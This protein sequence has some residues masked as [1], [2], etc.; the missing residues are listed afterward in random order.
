MLAYLT[1]YF[2]YSKADKGFTFAAYVF[3]Y[4]RSTHYHYL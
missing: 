1:V 2:Y 3:I 4:N